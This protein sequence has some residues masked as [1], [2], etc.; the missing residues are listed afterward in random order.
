[1]LSADPRQAQNTAVIVEFNNCYV[2]FADLAAPAHT[3][4]SCQYLAFLRNG[5]SLV[6]LS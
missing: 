3:V 1:M 6:I 2:C 5:D 4:G